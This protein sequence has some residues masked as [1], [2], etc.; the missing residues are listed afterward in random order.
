[1]WLLGE[2]ETRQRW[3]VIV[4]PHAENSQRVQGRG[5]LSH[6]GG[7]RGPP[8]PGKEDHQD[9][10]LGTR[11]GSDEL[12]VVSSTGFGGVKESGLFQV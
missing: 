5:L 4:V 7:K 1:M 6:R 12:L 10:W 8:L 3:R 11:R 9:P 2:E